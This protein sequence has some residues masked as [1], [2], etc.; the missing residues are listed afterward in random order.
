MGSV[1]EVT[2]SHETRLGH[3]YYA[4]EPTFFEP[5]PDEAFPHFSQPNRLSAD[6]DRT[7]DR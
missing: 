3:G 2:T 6:A 5:V 7:R 4:K 1:E